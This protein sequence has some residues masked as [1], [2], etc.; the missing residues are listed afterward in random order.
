MNKGYTSAILIAASVGFTAI[1]IGE[2]GAAANLDLTGGTNTQQGQAPKPGDSAKKWRDFIFEGAKPPKPR[3]PAKPLTPG[4]KEGKE[5]LRTFGDLKQFYDLK[6][7]DEKRYK[8]I[9][10]K[11][12]IRR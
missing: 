10:E 8:S 1:S 6:R 2:A 11:L 4:M 7:T 12:G 5:Y 9:I 3:P